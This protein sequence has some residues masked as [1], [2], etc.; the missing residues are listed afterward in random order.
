M[1]TLQALYGRSPREYVADLRAGVA[2]LE[3]LLAAAERPVDLAAA[4]EAFARQAGGLKSAALKGAAAA[5]AL[6][7]QGQ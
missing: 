2:E 3:R 1:S 4:L 5:R 7:A 6:S